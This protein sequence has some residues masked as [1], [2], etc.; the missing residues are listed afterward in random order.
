FTDVVE[1]WIAA[2]AQVIAGRSAAFPTHAIDEDL[3]CVH[4]N[5]GL[6][7]RIELFEGDEPGSGD[8]PR[9][10]FAGRPHIEDDDLAR[11]SRTV[12]L[13]G[14]SGLLSRYVREQTSIENHVS[15]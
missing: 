11:C 3:F 6:I 8:V 15:R 10:I 1:V 12:L 4:G 13:D 14:C 9:C 5:F 7:S 2:A